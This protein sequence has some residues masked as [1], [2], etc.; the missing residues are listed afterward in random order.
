M[1]QPD[2]NKN[3]GDPNDES[4]ITKFLSNLN[5]STAIG[6]LF[7]SVNHLIFV[8]HLLFRAKIANFIMQEIL[9][10]SC[11]IRFHRA[12]LISSQIIYIK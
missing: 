9:S 2:P 12:L 7:G 3:P 1:S 6:N 8:I 11:M 5:P 10:I 4:K